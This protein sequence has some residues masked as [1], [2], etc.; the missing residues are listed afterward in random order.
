MLPST[1]T[2]DVSGKVAYCGPTK[3]HSPTEETAKWFVFWC[4]VALGGDDGATA[5]DVRAYLP[6]NS[7][8]WASVGKE[9]SRHLRSTQLGGLLVPGQ[10]TWRWTL[11]SPPRW[12]PG[13]WAGREWLQTQRAS[14][15]TGLRVDS[16]ALG[17][18]ELLSGNAPAAQAELDKVGEPPDD[19]GAA[20][21]DLLSARILARQE[22]DEALQLLWERQPPAQNNAARALRVR[23]MAI[24]AFR[25]RS[26]DPEAGREAMGRL[27]CHLEQCGDYAGLAMCLNVRGT[28]DLRLGD[29]VAAEA[30]FERAATIAVVTGD[31]YLVQGALTNLS[32]VQALRGATVEADRNLS[33]ALWL[34]DQLG[35]GRDSAQTEVWAAERALARG[36]QSEAHAWIARAQSLVAKLDSDWEQAHFLAAR[37]A[38][39]AVWPCEGVVPSRDIAAAERLF[40]LAGDEANRARMARLRT[41]SG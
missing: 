6:W 13:E 41:R 32:R 28:L 29:R 30:A 35:L 11:A 4:V 7:A 12:I 38:V 36:D 8:K 1:L 16:L 19:W 2:L 31:P 5:E 24:R 9:A 3:A 25:S 34:S 15:R 21:A 23:L 10:N 26:S 17:M 33:A 27:A 18:V 40:L 14:P 20:A 22:D 39:C 37:A